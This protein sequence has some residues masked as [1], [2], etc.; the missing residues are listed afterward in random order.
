MRCDEVKADLVA[1][2]D[3]ELSPEE[4]VAIDTHLESCTSCRNEAKALDTSCDLLGVIGGPTD[5]R[6]DFAGN[7][8]KVAHDGDP[9]CR[10]IQKE[11]VAHLDGELTE[12]DARPVV[13]HL[14]ECADCREEADRLRST[15]DALLQWTFPLPEVDLLPR[16]LP[17]YRPRRRVLRLGSLAAAASLLLCVGVAALLGGF[18]TDEPPRDLL[19]VMDQLDA[20]TL[21]L[22]EDPDLTEV[23]EDLDYLESMG[24]EALAMMNGS[25]G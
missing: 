22:L 17:H 4:R 3:G 12:E 9:W 6:I 24:D 18:A 16:V 13:D 25:G 1:W 11:L 2:L 19:L 15:G 5:S 14:A 8:L 23:A 20:D 7:V 10:H 21:D